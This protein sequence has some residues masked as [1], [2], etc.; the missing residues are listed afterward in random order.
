MPR[1]RCSYRDARPRIVTPIV[2]RGGFV[3]LAPTPAEGDRIK[4]GDNEWQV[5]GIGMDSNEK[6][7]V[8]L[9]PRREAKVRTSV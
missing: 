7:V 1:W 2:R 3:Q 5:I 9:G 8:T 6:M 4:R